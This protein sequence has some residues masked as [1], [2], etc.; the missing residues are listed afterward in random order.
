[1]LHHG[2]GCFQHSFELKLSD[3]GCRES[4]DLWIC[5]LNLVHSTTK[6]DSCKALITQDLEL[7]LP[8]EVLTENYYE[9]AFLTVGW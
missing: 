5:D 1:M 3:D 7:D 8:D 2:G 9:R 4:S 6:S